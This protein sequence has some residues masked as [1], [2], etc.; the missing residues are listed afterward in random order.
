MPTSSLIAIA[1]MGTYLGVV[2]KRNLPQ[3]PNGLAR[4][5]FAEMWE[6]FSFYGMRALLVL[7]M[8]KQ[9]HYEDKAASLVYGAYGALVYAT[10]LM[11]G[12]VADRL[13]GN[14]RTVVLGCVLMALGHFVLAIEHPIA[15]YGALGLLVVGNGFFKPNMSSIVG[16]LYEPGDL[17]RD[18]GF[19]IFYMGVNAGA[20]LAPLTCGAIGERYG[21]HYGFGL[22]GIGMLLGM[23]VFVWNSDAT[24]GDIGKPADPDRAR[25]LTPYI[26]AGAFLLVPVVGVLL[27][28]HAIVERTL[29]L[30][31]A[32]GFAY[33]IYTALKSEKVER[34]RL[35][36]LMGLFFFSVMFWMFFEQAGSS[37]NL[38]TDRNVDRHLGGELIP[39]TAFQSVNAALIVL[40]GPLFTWIWAQTAKREVNPR[41]PVKFALAL[42][43]VGLGFGVLVA[44]C[45][46]ASPDGYVALIYLLGAY[47]LHTTGELCLSP[48]GLSTVTKLAPPRMVSFTLGFWYLSNSLAH[49]LGGIVAGLTA[50]GKDPSTLTAMDTLPLYT[51]VF[52]GVAVVAFAAG[53]I[54]WIFLSRLLQKW[55]HGVH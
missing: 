32:G 9:L 5:F 54:L 20:F 1:V 6:R 48:V 12:F 39:T 38:F 35:F 8:T 13:L 51:Q 16:K 44:G 14:R 26:W 3:H 18:S 2:L 10:P 29:P 47:L 27:Q 37:M 45:Q 53:L 49:L 23:I 28:H 40:L 52:G 4:L 11:G 7:Y 33:M 46:L 36:A 30:V 43:Q 31:I 15:F 17:R 22:A 55:M 34:E 42:M 24:F 50:S 25:Q 21:W 41:T 19:T